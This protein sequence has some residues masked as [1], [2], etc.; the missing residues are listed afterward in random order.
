[1]PPKSDRWQMAIGLLIGNQIAG[2]IQITARFRLTATDHLYCFAEHPVVLCRAIVQQGDI[3]KL[4][5]RDRLIASKAVETK[6]IRTN[7]TSRQ[8]TEETVVGMEAGLL[9]VEE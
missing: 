2:D 3:S 7:G 6:P 9:W 8:E 1:M 5:R 4:S